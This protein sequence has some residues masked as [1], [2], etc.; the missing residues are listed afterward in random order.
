MKNSQIQNYICVKES[1][2]NF[3]ENPNKDINQ[4]YSNIKNEQ[5]DIIYINQSIKTIMTLIS[6]KSQN[7]IKNNKNN[8]YTSK[9]IYVMKPLKKKINLEILAI[10]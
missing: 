8:N 1:T 6:T 5:K 3:D 4:T 10:K 2:T 7:N 9:R